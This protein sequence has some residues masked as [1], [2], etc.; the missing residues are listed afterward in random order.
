MAGDQYEQPYILSMEMVPGKRADPSLWLLGGD[1]RRTTCR[2][3]RGAAGDTSGAQV[4][5]D[6][7]SICRG[8]LP[9]YSQPFYLELD[10]GTL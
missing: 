10:T 4:N 9:I 7:T 1:G 6:L 3:G 5:V 2:A 8:L